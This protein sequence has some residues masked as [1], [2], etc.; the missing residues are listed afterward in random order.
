MAASV[1]VPLLALANVNDPLLL[2]RIAEVA[3]VVPNQLNPRLE[4]ASSGVI[5]RRLGLPRRPLGLGVTVGADL[6]PALADPA[7]VVARF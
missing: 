1:V 6:G 4:V 2:R 5:L 3:G 7:T